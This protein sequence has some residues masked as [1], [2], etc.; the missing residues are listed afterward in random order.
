V[1]PELGKIPVEHEEK[2]VTRSKIALLVLKLPIAARPLTSP[3]VG[4]DFISTPNP[5]DKT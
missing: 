4:K 5:T 1:D 3:E 2:G